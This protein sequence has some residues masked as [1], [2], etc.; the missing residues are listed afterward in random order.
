MTSIPANIDLLALALALEALVSYPDPVWRLIGHPVAWIGWLI[1]KLDVTLNREQLAPWHRRVHGAMALVAVMV[2][3]GGAAY[4]MQRV[5]LTFAVGWV[6]VVILAASLIAQRSLYRHVADVADALER[7][8]LAT[9]RVAVAKV[10]GRNPAMLDEA[11]I[12]RAAIETLAENFSDGVIAPAF[13][14][15]IGGLP[16]MVAYKAA[17]TAD[18]MIGHRTRRHEAFGWAAARFDDLVNLPASRLATCL[19]MV[20]AMLK[21]NAAPLA[22]VRAVRRDAWRHRSPNA[23]WC[24]AAMAGALGLKLAGPRIYGDVSVDDAWMGIGRAAATVV[25]IR[26]ALN[27]YRI[28]CGIFWCVTV[29]IALVLTP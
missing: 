29:V 27:L 17:N 18:S 10:V 14:F 20:A 5:V 16:G 24:E 2:I 3:A 26:A 28:A 19:L 9:G 21:P 6:A 12:C 4:L 15:V 13:W 11:G 1:G 7:G 25:D 8:G 22:A 23:G